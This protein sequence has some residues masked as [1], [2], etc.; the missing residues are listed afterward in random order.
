MYKAFENV[1]NKIIEEEW[2]EVTKFETNL[3]WASA[4]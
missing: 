2:Q 1:E 4:F 3:I